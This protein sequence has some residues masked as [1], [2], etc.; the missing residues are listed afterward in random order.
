MA[1]KKTTKKNKEAKE[2]AV[3]AKTLSA[4]I[5]APRIT[6]KAA[7]NADKGIYTFNVLGSATKNEVRKEI[8]K[9][10]KVKSVKVN[11]INTPKKKTMLR[12]RPSMHK[13]GKKAVVYLKKGDKIEFAQ[14]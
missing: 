9:L 14:L 3:I 12:G 10:Y 8:E 6:E 11:M 13:G 4:H 7:I 2:K 1:E 5:K